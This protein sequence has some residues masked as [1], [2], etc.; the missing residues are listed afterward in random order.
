MAVLL[1]QPVI[2]AL[3]KSELRITITGQAGLSFRFGVFN[4]SKVGTVFAGRAL[5]FVLE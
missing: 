2:I 5:Y 3:F 1:L 4:G